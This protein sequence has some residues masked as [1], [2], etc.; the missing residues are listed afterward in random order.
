SLPLT[1]ANLRNLAKPKPSMATVSPRPNCSTRESNGAVD[2][3]QERIKLGQYNI[4][5]DTGSKLPTELRT[6]VDCTFRLDRPEPPCPNAKQMVGLRRA[7]SFLNEKDGI[8]MMGRLLLFDGKSPK[9]P[10][11][12]EK[13]VCREDVYLSS[14][15]L[16]DAPNDHVPTYHGKLA[17]A[18]ADLVVGYLSHDHAMSYDGPRLK[19]V[20]T[21][22]EDDWVG[23]YALTQ[24]LRFPFLTSQW[25]TPTSSTGHFH[26]QTQSARDG[27]TIVNYLDEFFNISYGRKATHLEAYHVSVT[28]DIQTV[29]IW[30]HWRTDD[31]GDSDDADNADE[32]DSTDSTEKMPTHHMEQIYSCMFEDEAGLSEARKILK[33]VLDYSLGARVHAI[34]SALPLFQ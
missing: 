17:Q 30:I 10:H 15:F 18:R 21:K 12:T 28:T 3:K 19:T 33:N 9:N 1:Q 23:T 25:K 6:L 34:R 26:A 7:A 27:V 13:I 29:R 5:V 24:S 2:M 22:K 4:W 8:E 16:P 31:A 20:F 11:G 32:D 14:V